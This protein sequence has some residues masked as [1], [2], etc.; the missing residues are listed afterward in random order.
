PAPAWQ[1]G[2]SFH[3]GDRR[4]SIAR[5]KAILPGRWR[6]SCRR[7]RRPRSAKSFDAWVLPFP[8]LSVGRRSFLALVGIEEVADDLQ[9]AVGFLDMRHVA[10]VLEDLPAHIL[11]P[12]LVGLH[13]RRRRLVVFA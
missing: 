7:V 5:A 13:R 12:I 4:W 6:R 8:F 10:G 9:I 11:D 2:A 3:R 1:G